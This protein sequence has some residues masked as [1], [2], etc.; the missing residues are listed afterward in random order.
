ME[1]SGCKDDFNCEGL[2]QEVSEEIFFML[3][4]NHLCDILVK[5][6]DAF[7]TYKIF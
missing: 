6:V 3:P 2:A 7:S 4:K 1:D 5:N